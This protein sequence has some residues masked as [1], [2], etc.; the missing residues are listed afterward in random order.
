MELAAAYQEG[1]PA[2]GAAQSIRTMR[3]WSE[4]EDNRYLE[5]MQAASSQMT[6][7]LV[8]L[9]LLSPQ[10]QTAAGQMAEALVGAADARGWNKQRS[11]GAELSAATATLSAALYEFTAPRRRRWRPWG[12]PTPPTD[13]V[14]ASTSA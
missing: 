6:P 13:R 1:N 4:A 11:A 2:R 10:F 3:E 14:S 8:S 9:S 12:Y 7:A 5:R